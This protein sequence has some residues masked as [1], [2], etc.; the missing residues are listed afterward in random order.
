MNE[1][2]IHVLVVDDD[3]LT[4]SLTGMVLEEAGYDVTLAEGGLDALEQLKVGSAIRAVVSDLNMPGMDGLQLFQELRRLGHDQ[5]FVVLTGDGAEPLKAA[6][7]D[8]DA[9]VTKDEQFQETLPE[10]LAALLSR[11]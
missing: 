4:A 7:P 9:V 1:T 11:A 5:L 6:H 8:L 3:A 10:T 2:P